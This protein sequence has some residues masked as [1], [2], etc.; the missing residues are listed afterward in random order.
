MA[1]KHTE[2]DRCHSRVTKETEMS[3]SPTECIRIHSVDK[4]TKNG[5]VFSTV[6]SI[7]TSGV[8]RSLFHPLAT[9]RHRI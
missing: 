7:P 4:N 5:V 8:H 2:A 1:D 6:I 3:K 9:M